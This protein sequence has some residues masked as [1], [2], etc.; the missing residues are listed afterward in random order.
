L[1]PR[2]GHLMQAIGMIH[3]TST[4]QHTASAAGPLADTALREFLMTRPTAWLVDELITAARSAPL[5]RARLEQAAGTEPIVDVSGVLDRLDRVADVRGFVPYGEAA[6]FAHGIR[7]ELAAVETLRAEGF[8]AAA[9]EV[10]EHAITVIEGALG[11]VD[12]SDGEVGGVLDDAQELHAQACIEAGPEPVELAER[13]ARWALRSNWEVFLDSPG[14]HAETLGESGL[15]RFREIVDDASVGLSVG[16]DADDFDDDDSDDGQPTAFTIRYLQEQ[17][18]AQRG[19]DE[20]VDVLAQDLSSAYR[21]HRIATVLADDNRVEEAL[22]WLERGRNTTFGTWHDDRLDKLAADLHRRA[23]RFAV[24]TQMVAEE[25]AASPTVSGYER[26]RVF[27]TDSVEWDRRRAEALE[28][29]RAMPVAALPAP[30]HR[31]MAEASGHGVLVRVLIE[32]GDIDGAWAAAQQGGCP[33]SIWM[34]VAEAR[35]VTHPAD[36]VPV[37]QRLGANVLEG[38]NRA[39][40][41]HGAALIRRAHRFAEAAGLTP[42]STAWIV[43]VREKNRRRPALQD[44]FNRHHLPKVR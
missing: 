12:D 26:L 33:S 25:F 35:G 32:E 38:G 20:L 23:G 31:S 27:A 29:L 37:F 7:V 22:A 2:S 39:A 10:L 13:L 44:E 24:A 43:D 21:F 36:A 4:P 18:A 40:Y 5:L 42:E 34:E 6:S 1:L 9:I 17:L 14:T 8:V 30:G 3:R 41:A 11:F 16:D 28:V 15:A 19:T